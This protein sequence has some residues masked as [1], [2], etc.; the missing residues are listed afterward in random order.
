M[1]GMFI[2]LIWLLP[3]CFS[4]YRGNKPLVLLCFRHNMLMLPPVNCFG[5][6]MITSVISS[7]ILGPRVT[8]FMTT[9]GRGGVVCVNLWR[10][11]HVSSDHMFSIRLRGVDTGVRALSNTAEET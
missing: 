2:M 3:S 8:V 1:E 4:C 10:S 11:G 6:W 5:V 9:K 7:F